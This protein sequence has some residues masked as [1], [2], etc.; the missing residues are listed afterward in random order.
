MD[1]ELL[2][3]ILWLDSLAPFA[4]RKARS[5][6]LLPRCEINKLHRDVELPN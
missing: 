4:Y 5:G 1:L 3:S 2:P 6:E